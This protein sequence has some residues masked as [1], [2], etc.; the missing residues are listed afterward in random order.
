[1]TAENYEHV[2]GVNNLEVYVNMPSNGPATYFCLFVI[3]ISVGND[4]GVQMRR[5]QI[6]VT[7]CSRALRLQFVRSRCSEWVV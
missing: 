6:A 5:V 7:Q 2:R 4:G 3:C 1:M